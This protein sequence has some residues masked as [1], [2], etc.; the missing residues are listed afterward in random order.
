MEDVLTTVSSLLQGMMHLMMPVVVKDEETKSFCLNG[1]KDFSVDD[2][3]AHT[4]PKSPNF[5]NSVEM[6]A[7][8][9]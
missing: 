7:V 4:H 6:F 2:F 9:N 5:P 8:G 3:S 1:L